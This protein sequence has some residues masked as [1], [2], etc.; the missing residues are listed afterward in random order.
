MFEVA[1]EVME[2]FKQTI[3]D[4]PLGK[5]AMEA[6]AEG[7]FLPFNMDQPLAMLA[8]PETWYCPIEN[9]KWSGERGN[10]TWYPDPDY[11]PKKHNPDGKTMGEILEKYG[12][13]GIEFKDGEPDFS[14]IS[15]GTVEI[16][17]FS[18]NRS[19]NFDLA[20]KKLAEQRGCTAD[21]IKEWRKENGY[22]WHECK[23]MKT[24]QL[25]PS[26]VHG[27]ISHSGGVAEVKK[28]ANINE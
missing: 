12:I 3:S 27:N 1:K 6:K 2:V 23:D 16:G 21:D 20:D 13:D 24:M 4:S 9:G 8:S 28:E 26:E 22:T 17:S 15:E 25:V 5:K 7:G 10:S 14:K 18:D 11:I 19:D